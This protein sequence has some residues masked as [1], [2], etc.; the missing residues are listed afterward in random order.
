MSMS[1]GRNM[2][3][4]DQKG[5]GHR[6]GSGTMGRQGIDGHATFPSFGRWWGGR[7]RQGDSENEALRE[8]PLRKR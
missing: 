3:K 5:S 1:G 8:P 6:K 2:Q 4:K 7:T